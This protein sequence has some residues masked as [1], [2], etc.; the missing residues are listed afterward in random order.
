MSHGSEYFAFRAGAGPHKRTAA[1]SPAYTP[2]ARSPFAD[3]STGQQFYKEMAW[4]ADQKIST[5]W[6]EAN[7]G[8]GRCIPPFW[9]DSIVLGFCCHCAMAAETQNGR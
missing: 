3:V 6:V 8:E 1:G 5:G 2:P 7:A 9:V 4:L